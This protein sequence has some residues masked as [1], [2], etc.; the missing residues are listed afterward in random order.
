MLDTVI[1][2]SITI[3]HLGVAKLIDCT[4]SSSSPGL[5]NISPKVL[6]NT[7]PTSSRILSLIFNQSLLTVEFLVLSSCC[8]DVILGW[9]FLRDNLA[10]ID[11]AREEVLLSPV[12]CFDSE[13]TV[14]PSC[15]GLGGGS[16]LVMTGA[17]GAVDVGVEL[18]SS[19]RDEPDAFSMTCMFE[20]R[21]HHVK[22]VIHGQRLESKRQLYCRHPRL[23]YRRHRRRRYHT[24]TLLTAICSCCPH[25][26]SVTFAPLTPTLSLSSRAS[27]SIIVS[28]NVHALASKG[29]AAPS[30][31]T[32]LTDGR[33]YIP[34]TN[35]ADVAA[36]LP[37]GFVVATAEDCDPIDVLAPLNVTP[38]PARLHTP[39]NPTSLTTMIASTLSSDDRAS[40]ISLLTTYSHLFDLGKPPL[41][42]AKGVHHRIDTG[43]S[44]P[45]RQRPYRVSASERAVIEKEVSDMLSR[46]IIQPSSSPWASP[47]VLVTK[48]DG[49][50]RFCVD[51]R[52]LNKITRRDVYPMPRIDD[53]LDALSDANFF[54]S[55][56]LRSGYWQI[57]MA[58]SDIEKTAF[59][60]P[61][62]LYEFKVMPFGLTNAPATFER[63]MDTVL[64]G[65]RW[66][67]CLCYLDDVIVYSQTF[68]QHLDRLRAVFDCFAAAGLQLNHKKCHFGYRQIKV[69]GHIVSAQG[70]SPDP[71]KVRAV[72]DFPTPTNI[73]DL[74]SFIGLCSWYTQTTTASNVSTST[75]RYIS[76]EFRICVRNR[77]WF[78]MH[79][80][81]FIFNLFV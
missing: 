11:C 44:P 13:P 17:T 32:S 58:D 9:D 1:T 61:D 66:H 75:P 41:G 81:L 64:R 14:P 72:D 56:D 77:R 62:G 21:C 65:L 55:L 8:H 34:I 22:R 53:A 26:R 67:V 73:R 78:L 23:Q 12:P 2:P 74:R 70:I 28:P 27:Y 20:R 31:L 30:C 76:A 35:T 47:V 57:P 40:L 68:P 19:T 37:A 10:V 80:T 60:T 71:D 59:T 79:N 7:S 18:G 42:V 63:L 51:Y 24:I 3:D 15:N 4:R 46:G 43:T 16:R 5:D 54:S 33:T 25:P 29:L 69:L 45:V 49:S 52:R 48:K 38:E 39:V 50:I 6:K 36:L